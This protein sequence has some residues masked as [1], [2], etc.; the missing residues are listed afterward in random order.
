MSRLDK[1]VTG[2]VSTEST[3]DEVKVNKQ[4]LQ[5]ILK[6]HI[7]TGNVLDQIKKHA[8]YN[9]EYN[10][11]GLD[12]NLTNLVDAL[13]VIATTPTMEVVEN[14]EVLDI[15]PRIFHSILGAGTESV[16][17]LEA[18]NFDGDMDLVNIGEEFGDLNWYQAIF[19]DAAGIKWDDILD[20]NAEKLFKSN[21][22]RYKDG[23]ADDD[24]NER[25]LTDEREV[26]NNLKIKSS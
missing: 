18:L 24:A 12:K 19:C 21:K 10:I 16:E 23:F 17:L 13:A 6:M 20:T 7:A 15:N 11:D 26:L 3:I 22:A 14:E 4:F 9:R 2:A 8:F 25:N 5:Q 1:Y